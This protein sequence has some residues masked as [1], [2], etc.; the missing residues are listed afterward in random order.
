MRNVIWVA[1]LSSMVFAAGC[2][3]VPPKTDV[4]ALLVEAWSSADGESRVVRG[5]TPQSMLRELDVAPGDDGDILTAAYPQLLAGCY[6]THLPIATADGV[7][8]F[9]MVRAKNQDNAACVTWVGKSVQHSDLL[10]ESRRCDFQALKPASMP[11][12]F[13][14]EGVRWPGG[15]QRVD[16]WLDTYCEPPVAEPHRVPQSAPCGTSNALPLA[17]DVGL[18]CTSYAE[19]GNSDTLLGVCSACANEACDEALDYALDGP[20]SYMLSAYGDVDWPETLYA[21]LYG[22]AAESRP[23]LDYWNAVLR[24][25][26][27]LYVQ[28]GDPETVQMTVFRGYAS[29]HDLLAS[30]L[31]DTVMHLVRDGEA[32]TYR[33]ASLVLQDVDID[34]DHTPS[35]VAAL[36]DAWAS[37]CTKDDAVSFG[38]HTVCPA[39]DAQPIVCDAGLAC[40]ADNASWLGR[41]ERAD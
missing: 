30:V 24:R 13:Y 27:A 9:H 31:P 10:Y 3:D 33:C 38:E 26:P 6:A 41:C 18:A 1:A 8:T 37:S 28:W 23:M 7:A 2:D 22:A 4:A 36:A 25:A 12:G 5:D 35:D 14:D 34:V 21:D 20:F 17:C 29:A 39:I 15:E 11:L 19:T 40:T 16:A 32:S